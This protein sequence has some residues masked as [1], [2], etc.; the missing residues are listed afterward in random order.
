MQQSIYQFTHF[1]RILGSLFFYE[2]NVPQNQGLVMLFQNSS[3]QADCDFLPENKRAEIQQNLQMQSLE[4]LD[5][6]YQKLFIGPNHLPAP[7]WG[8]V[9]LDKES[10]IFGDSLLALRA[11]LQA[12]Q[13]HFSL[14]QN[15]PEDHI[16]LMFMLTAYLAEQQPELLKPFLRDHFLTWAYRFFELFNAQNV[17]FYRGLG[18]LGEAL[19]KALQKNLEIEPLA[20]RLYR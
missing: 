5:E 19:L 20:V 17:P 4:Q 8:S 9:Y 1:A 13:I 6:D 10:V 7:L 16:G 2:P 18:M 12:H 15:E 14:A 3:W 11:F